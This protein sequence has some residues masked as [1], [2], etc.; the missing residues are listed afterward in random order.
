MA[1]DGSFI[2]RFVSR[3]TIH[4]REVCRDMGGGGEVSQYLV[5]NT[6][7]PS[8]P[9]PLTHALGGHSNYTRLV[10][11]KVNMLVNREVHHA[12]TE[13][14]AVAA[15]E[16]SKIRASESLWFSINHNRLN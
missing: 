3:S 15:A 4:T 10:V 9:G 11:M 7:P 12:A 2:S 8:E 14:E 16:I 6:T 5:F 1:Q 13:G